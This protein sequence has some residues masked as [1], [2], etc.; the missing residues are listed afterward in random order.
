MRA[1]RYDLADAYYQRVLQI[2]PRD[3]HAQAGMIALRSQQLDP[4]QV[5]SRVKSLLAADREANVLYFTLGNQYA[6]QGRW[7]EAQQA[8]FKAFSADPGQ[9]GFRLQRRGQP[10][11]A[12]PAQARARVLPARAALA[13]KRARQLRRRRSRARACSSSR[14]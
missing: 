1:Q 2:D 14:R 8:Y 6:Q 9:S 12:A 4:V 10:G 13:Q 3:P 11:P 7:A 5:E